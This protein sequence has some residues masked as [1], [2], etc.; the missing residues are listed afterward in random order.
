MTLY[1]PNENCTN[2]DC[3]HRGKALKKAEFREVVVYTVALGAC[4][5]YSIH[6]FCP[7][8]ILTR[9]YQPKLTNLSIFIRMQYKLP[10]QL[11]RTRR[12]TGLLWWH[13]KISSSR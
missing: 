9:I 3:I 12:S 10:S 8:K 4:R 11:L 2:A 13:A 5:A 7:G 6:L 1:P